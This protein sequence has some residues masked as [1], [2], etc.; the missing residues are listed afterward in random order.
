MADTADSTFTCSVG[1]RRPAVAEAE[2][3][4]RRTSFQTFLLLHHRTKGVQGCSAA[5]GGFLLFPLLYCFVV[6]CCSPQCVGGW[7][8]V[9]VL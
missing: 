3:G 7:V 5:P 9:G 8:G 1:P 2:A 4:E 6:V